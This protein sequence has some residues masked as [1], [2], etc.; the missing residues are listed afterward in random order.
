[1]GLR[2][3]YRIQDKHCWR[4]FNCAHVLQTYGMLGRA[5]D[6]IHFLLRFLVDVS[7]LW[8]RSSNYLIAVAPIVTACKMVRV[9]PLYK[10]ARCWCAM[11]HALTRE[12]LNAFK[13]TQT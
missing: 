12:R 13:T 7:K 6:T 2:E 9:Q 3:K 1:M 11:V 10:I 4:I 8:K 5:F